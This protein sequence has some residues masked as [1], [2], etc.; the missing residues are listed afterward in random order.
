MIR[1]YVDVICL[2]DKSG[3]V[4]PLCIIWDGKKKYEITRVKEVC[5]RSSLKQGGTGTRFTCL[6]KSN[7]IRHLNYDR[8]KWFVEMYDNIV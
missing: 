6:F 1:K 2:N 5:R 7:Q 4:K 3:N 8:G